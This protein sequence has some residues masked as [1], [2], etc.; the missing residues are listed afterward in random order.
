M[1]SLLMKRWLVVAC[2][3]LM[4][5]PLCAQRV[6]HRFDPADSGATISFDHN[7]NP[8]DFSVSPNLVFSQDG[9]KTYVAA[10]GSAKIL[11]LDTDL[12][13]LL[14][15]VDLAANPLR[16]LLTPDGLTLVVVSL[17]FTKKAPGSNPSGVVSLIRLSDLNVRTVKFDKPVDFGFGSNV[18]LSNNGAAG[19]ISSTGTDEIVRFELAGATET[20]RLKLNGGSRPTVLTMAHSGEFF[21]AVA[22]GNFFSVDPDSV[23]MVRTADL[24]IQSTFVPKDDPQTP[25]RDHN[26][27]FSTNVAFSADDKVAIIGDRSGTEPPLQDLAFLASNVAF[28]FDP[29]NGTEL[30]ALAVGNSPDFITLTPD[31]RDFIIV[32]LFQLTFVNVAEQIV[33]SEM[34]TPT[35]QGYNN[36]T[37]IAFSRDGKKGY[38][39]S[40]EGDRVFVFDVFNAVVENEV[41]VGKDPDFLDFPQDL[42]VSPSGKLLAVLNFL[43]N[44][45]DYLRDT[46]IGFVPYFVSNDIF[47][48][49]V[50]I[51]NLGTN[52]SRAVITGSSN[53]GIPL[54]DDIST[55][56]VVEF[57]NPIEPVIEPGKQI[58]ATIDQ[59]FTADT[60]VS[61]TEGTVRFDSDVEGLRGFFLVLAR[62][63]LRMDGGVIEP[64]GAGSIDLVFPI[65]RV[66]DGFTTQISIF[67]PNV[68][69]TA[70]AV[71]F[72][73][74][75]GTI[76][77]AAQA[78]TI[79]GAA[80]F[81]AD[82]KSLFPDAEKVDGG[83]VLAK[84]Q[85]KVLGYQRVE[86]EKRLEIFPGLAVQFGDPIATTLY[87]PH[88]AVRGGYQS[89]FNL[90]NTSE[91]TITA[92]VLVHGADGSTLGD[93]GPIE[94]EKL[95]QISF[96]LA[97]KFSL[98]S[99]DVISGWVEVVSSSQTIAG[100]VEIFAFDGR[101]LTAV[102]LSRGGL[103]R[104]AFTHVADGLG[105]A[106]GL[107]L[108]NANA[109]PAAV[110]IRVFDAAGTQ[111][112]QAARTL[113]AGERLV[114]LLSEILPGIAP[115]IGGYIRIE[116]DQNLIGLELFYTTDLES[117]SAVLPTPLPN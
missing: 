53:L 43:T 79:P 115:Q 47:Y 94:I 58:A 51:A 99:S 95:K 12:G 76:T 46:F 48:T 63:G 50:A 61:K 13:T 11:I 77:D 57:V 78:F 91:E 24:T 52:T 68:S 14:Q 59:L 30:K 37:R 19:F 20:G 105:F 103:R 38:V 85:L 2:A 40:P 55:V 62:D 114:G 101:A 6:A 107:A 9:S 4:I 100:S 117:L 113:E 23:V 49:G 84:A 80:Q 89:F 27:L 83:Y 34:Q 25:F 92:R 65:V 82:V 74:P 104:L 5:S 73:A 67:N 87:A 36:S 54:V 69:N 93:S 32:T 35:A 33:A 39:A 102:P 60:V 75:D 22:V 88:F 44:T 1:P 97:E 108:L 106:T 66:K 10:P 18:V 17:E 7:S 42:A 26:F 96:D 45:V 41:L 21:A 31:G 81:L 90:A 56:D 16:M 28:L 72:I 109:A 116:S 98:E 110:T 64:L 71:R 15:T 112:A 86:D 3:G 8:I 111:T 29:S 70:L